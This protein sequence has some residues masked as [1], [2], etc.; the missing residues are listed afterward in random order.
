MRSLNPNHPMSQFAQ[1]NAATFI[2]A[3]I[4]KLRQHCPNLAV[5]LTTEDLAELGRVFNADGQCGAVTCRGEGDRII[6]QLVDQATGRMLMA[7]KAL[8]EDSPNAKTMKFVLQ[9]RGRAQW[10]ADRLLLANAG[11]PL[12]VEAAEIL[13][14]LTWEPK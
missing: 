8:D 14:L 9:A 5:E 13:K 10:V 12:C 2:A 6:L 1:A 7:D 3:M 11:D 4:W